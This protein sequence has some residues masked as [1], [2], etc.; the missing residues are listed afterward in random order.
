[1]P[2]S[3]SNPRM[4]LETEIFSTDGIFRCPWL[5]HDLH[6]FDASMERVS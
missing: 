4:R 3:F 2:A 6:G 5:F 1:M